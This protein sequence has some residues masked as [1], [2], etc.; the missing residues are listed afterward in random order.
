ME[1]TDSIN[2]FKD[3]PDKGEGSDHDSMKTLSSTTRK[4]SQNG[5]VTQFKATSNGLESLET[6]EVYSPEEVKI[7]NFYRFEG[8][9]DPSDNA[10]L[11]VLETSR[12]E[13]GT[14]T[15]AYGVYT[16]LKVSEFVKQVEEIEK[17]NTNPPID[18][19]PE[20]QEAG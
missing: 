6:H 14:L 20:D 2:E 11:Y 12:G 10:I 3:R 17:A 18:G 16:D 8:E 1:T 5:Y 9:S 15:D 4:L 13:K 7:I 19:R